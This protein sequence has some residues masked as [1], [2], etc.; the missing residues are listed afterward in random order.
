MQV[1]AERAT[2]GEGG[3]TGEEM[4]IK[5]FTLGP[6]QRFP[7][8]KIHASDEGETRIAVGHHEGNVVLD[9]GTPTVWV[10]FPPEQALE[11]AAAIQQHAHAAKGGRT[12]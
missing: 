4:K 9:F 8:G 3:E 6:T 10:G 12:Q 5:D 11:L 7:R 1:R 2:A